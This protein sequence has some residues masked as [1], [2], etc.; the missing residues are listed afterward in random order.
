MVCG[1]IVA[2]MGAILNA[3]SSD[4]RCGCMVRGGERPMIE[5]RAR[6]DSQQK[7]LRRAPQIITY[8]DAIHSCDFHAR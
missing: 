5:Y 6:M 8:D 2:E 4:S 7:T 1:E 3:T